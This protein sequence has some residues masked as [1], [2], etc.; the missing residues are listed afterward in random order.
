MYL[1]GW[2]EES[3]TEK[4]FGELFPL[5]ELFF[6]PFGRKK[7]TILPQETKNSPLSLSVPGIFFPTIQN[8]HSIA[9]G[10]TLKD[11]FSTYRD[12]NHVH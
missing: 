7:T 3:W 11:F 4:L 5:E 9:L 12:T 2:K 8:I 1:Y 6:P 10:S